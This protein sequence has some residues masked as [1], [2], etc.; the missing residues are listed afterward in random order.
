[1]IRLIHNVDNLSYWNDGL[2]AS[3]RIIDASLHKFSKSDVPESFGPDDIL[4]VW[5]AAPSKEVQHYTGFPQKKIMLVGGMPAHATMH[6]YDRVVVETKFQQDELRRLGI[7]AKRAFGTNTA[8]FRPIED[9]VF[10]QAIY[11]AAFAKWKRHELFAKKWGVDGLAVGQFQDHEMECIEVV[12]KAGGTVMNKVRPEF[13]ARLMR[14]CRVV[15]IHSGVSGGGERSV[16]EAV[17][18]EKQVVL[19]DDN[20][21]LIGLYE[22]MQEKLLTEYDYARDLWRVIKELE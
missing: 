10:Y 16:L 19:E 5:G 7:D 14:H 4:L 12:R 21:K 17:A 20:P 6:D 9:E 11:P 15:S 18:M 8:V 22:E 3:A 1:M 13:L 2:R